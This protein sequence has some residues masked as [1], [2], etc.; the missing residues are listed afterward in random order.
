MQKE[1]EVILKVNSKQA[2]EKFRTL[3]EKAKS[4]RSKLADAFRSGD[5]RGIDDINKELKKVNREIDRMRTNAANI[6][7]AM[8]R[9]DQASPKELKRTIRLINDELNSGRVARGSEEWTAYIAKLK[10]VKAELA[11]VNAEMR[12]DDKEKSLLDK[13]KD[14]LGNWGLSAA[15][16]AAA[17][18]GIVVAGKKALQAYADMEAEEANVR[19]FTG[20]TAE[21]VAALNEEFKKIDT[22]TPR[23]EL[24]KLAQEAGRL[25]KTAPEDVLGFVKAGDQINIALDDLG[26]NA[27]LTLSKLTGIF[28]DEAKYGTEQSLLKV[29]SVINDL[30]QN[31]SASAPYL[32]EF[33]SRLGG[34]A[35]Q[36]K[37][38]ISQVMAFGAVLDTN[39]LNVEASATAVGQLITAIYKEPAKIAKAAG[40]DVTKFS[41]MVKTDMNGALIALFEQLNKFGGMQNLATVFDSMGTDG[42][43]AIPVLTALAGHIDELKAQQEA[44]SEAFREGTSVSKEAAIQN[45]T[46]QAQL[47][48]AK[49]NIHELVVSLGE[50]LWPV[51]NLCISGTSMLM[52]VLSVLVSFIANNKGVI[53]TLIATIVTYTTVAKASALVTKAWTVATTACNGVA[54]AFKA[55]ILALRIAYMELTGQT[56]K[57]EAAQRMFAMTTKANPLGLLMAGATAVIGTLITMIQKINDNRRAAEEAAREYEEWK[58]SISNV[59]DASAEYAAKELTRLDLLYN[60]AI[61]ESKSKDE[62]KKAVEQLQNLY[63]GY[64]KNLNSEQIS[65]DSLTQTY[66][67]LRDSILEAARAR[68]AADLIYENQK[69]IIK[70]EGERDAASNDRKNASKKRDQIRARNRDKDRRANNAATSVSGAMAMSGGGSSELYAHESTAAADQAVASATSRLIKSQRKINELNKANQRLA[71]EYRKSQA[72]QNQMGVNSGSGSSAGA[73]GGNKPTRGET[74]KERQE[75]EKAARQARQA[76]KEAQREAK[77]ALKKDLDDRKSLYLQ[78]EAENLMLYVTGRQTYADYLAQKENLDREYADDVIK[79]HENHNKLDIA[80][81]GQAL[82]TK[83]DM[84]RKQQE[85]RRRYSLSYLEKE[86]EGNTDSITSDYYDPSAR[87][88]QNK[89]ILTQRLLQEDLRYITEKKK[90]YS[91][92][93]EEWAALERE[94]NDRIRQDQLDK[95][96]ETAE[97]VKWYKENFTKES[98]TLQRETELAMLEQL[99]ARGLISEKDYQEAVK[100]LKEKYRDEDLENAQ[101]IKSEFVDILKDMSEAFAGLLEGFNWDDLTK[102]VENAC[103]LM[104]AAVSQYTAYAN[105]ERD[106]ELAKIE[107]RYDKEIAAAGKNSKKKKK[108][109]EQKEAEV[110]KVKKKYNDRAM[111]VEIAQAIAQTALAAIAAYASGSKVNV[112]LGPVAAALALA[113]GAVQIAT[114][115]KQHE[116]EAAGYYEGGFTR[117][118]PDNRRE[119]GVVHAN[120]FVANHQAVANPALSPVLRLIDTAQRNNTVGSLTA[121]DVSNALGQGAGV[122]ARGAAAMGGTLDSVVAGGLALAGEGA[123]RSAEAIDRLND[124]IADGIEAKVILDGEDGFHKKYQHLQ[125]LQNNPKR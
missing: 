87:E 120:E 98:A 70:L 67:R 93:S 22:R 47:D 29:G 119:A 80:A 15:T 90:L 13:I 18:T 12:A 53:V 48:K 10:E 110:A 34:I 102:L 121:A 96:K 19:K 114:I 26:E 36:S 62:R 50:K 21:E 104:S 58:R 83:A 40:M 60:A 97:A 37:M 106:L 123:I 24:N 68:A 76:E 61:D 51:M 66:Q 52:R 1:A 79:I 109:E 117:R 88:F 46:V 82:K 64:F 55:S 74:D 38:S 11:E 89:T 99:H 116:A 43:R 103:A 57:A 49:N 28:G 25:G 33:S 69:Q 124:T 27:V 3:E 23:E 17:I 125:K 54:S 107:K 84:L 44:A 113:A 111:K 85:S 14:G 39:N 9:L 81:Y 2:E 20:M 115:K 32:A 86:H 122:S 75:R 31:C 7:A 5:T 92:G 105:A 71:N 59:D 91:E 41:Q 8:V 45:N 6:K 72:F 35:A 4:L 118:D 77:E 108:L 30:S 16:G 94:Y 95:M 101:G 42:A 56:L 112:W 73:S 100:K 63:P 78:A 65:V